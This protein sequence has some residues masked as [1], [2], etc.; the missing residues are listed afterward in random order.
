MVG[1]FRKDLQQGNKHMREILIP[2]L[3]RNRWKVTEAGY[4]DDRYRG[5]D[6][7]AARADTNVT[8]QV[9]ADTR[10]HKT[11]NFYLQDSKFINNQADTLC[12][13]D[14]KKKTGYMINIRAIRSN[15]D[16]ILENSKK[17]SMKNVKPNG[18]TYYTVGRIISKDD[19]CEIVRIIEVKLWNPRLANK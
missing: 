5:I 11:N 17:H 4:N 10:I 15:W 13:I 3:K 6:L 12:Y 19:L 8:I 14:V 1:Q 7:F 2:Y 18:E 16:K 9:K